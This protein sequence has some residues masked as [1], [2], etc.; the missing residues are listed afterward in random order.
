MRGT[1]RSPYRSVITKPLA[2]SAL[3]AARNA[4]ASVPYSN[5]TIISQ[6]QRIPRQAK[7]SQSVDPWQREKKVDSAGIYLTVSE[8]DSIIISATTALCSFNRYGI[9]AVGDTRC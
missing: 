5:P 8:F 9:L 2:M 6:L 7:L 1:E 3:A 4:V